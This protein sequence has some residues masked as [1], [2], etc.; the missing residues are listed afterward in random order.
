MSYYLHRHRL[1][2]LRYEL[3]DVPVSGYSDSDWAVRR[4]TSDSVFIHCMAAI[5]W[6]SKRQPTVALSSCEAEI[7]AASDTA[8]EALYLNRVLAE[9]GQP[10]DGDTLDG[11]KTS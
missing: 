4:S 3:G 11:Q 9:L 8:K 6:S 5:C 1:L 2:G 10:C 7:V